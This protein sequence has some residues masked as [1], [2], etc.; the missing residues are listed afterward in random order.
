MM[1]VGYVLGGSGRRGAVEID[2][3]HTLA[4][5]DRRQLKWS[6]FTDSDQ[7]IGGVRGATTDDLASIC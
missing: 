2:G 6:D 1:S 4:P 3:E 5:D 7:L